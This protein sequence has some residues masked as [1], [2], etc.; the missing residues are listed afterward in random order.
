M[1]SAQVALAEAQASVSPVTASA[2]AR[3]ISRQVAV[4]AIAIGDFLSVML[5]GLLPALIYAIVGSVKIDQI[6]VVQSTMI[7]GLLSTLCFRL[8][9]MYETARMS[10]FPVKPG[11]LL[12]GMTCGLL[13]VLGIGFPTVLQNSHLFVWYAAWLS[14]SFTLLLLT[15]L[16]GRA[17]LARIAAAGRF[18]QRVAIFGAGSIARRVHDTFMEPG[19][20]IKFTGLYDDRMNQDRLNPEGLTVIGRLD[21]L[22]EE[23]RRG[24]IDNIIVALPQSADMRLA[25]ILS[26]FADLPVSTHIVT[27]LAMDLIDAGTSGYPTVSSIGPVGLLDVK[28]KS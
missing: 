10:E 25:G 18:D 17:M 2:P 3:R 8:R 4:D 23:A 1:S 19:L 11:E 12:I 5:G 27:H 15:R 22:V 16:V 21:D 14:C 28:K 7:A 24:H 9:G 26:K 20:D 6:M 13:G